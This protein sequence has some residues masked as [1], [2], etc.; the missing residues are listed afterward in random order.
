MAKSLQDILQVL[1]Q[2]LPK[3]RQRYGVKSLSIFGSYVRRE[4]RRRSDLDILVEFEDRPLT[5]FD[6]VRLEQ[7]LSDL[8]GIK[9]DL[10][11]RSTLKPAIGG[12]ILREAMSV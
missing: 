5:L 9:V 2:H 11:E 8:L 12:Q 6:F 3:L 10:V 4:A 1:R 7:E